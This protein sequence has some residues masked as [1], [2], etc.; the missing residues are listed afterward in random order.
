MAKRVVGDHPGANMGKMLKDL[1]ADAVVSVR[2]GVLPHE[3]AEKWK[4]NTAFFE[5]AEREWAPLFQQVFADFLADDSLPDSLRAMLEEGADPGH[6][7]GFFV[8]VLAFIGMA[9]A[10][11]PQFGAVYVRGAVYEL[12][13]KTQN[14]PMSPADAADAVMRGLLDEGEGAEYAAMAGITGGIF[15]TM[16]ALIGEPPGVMDMVALW[17]RGAINSGQLEQGIKYS[18]IHDTYIPMVEQMAYSTMSPADAIEL[19]IKGVV[20]PSEAATWFQ[21]GGGLIEQ[22]N[23]LY[24]AAGDAIGNEQVLGLLNQG[25]ASES[26]VEATFG[27]SRMNPIFYPLA[28]QLR[29]K[30]LEPFQIAELLKANP[31]LGPQAAEWMTGLGYNAEQITAFIATN[32]KGAVATTHT[33]TQAMI[34][35]LFTDQVI[36]EDVAM[37]QLANL[38]YDPGSATMIL[39]LAIAKQALSQR[40]TAV[41]AVRSALLARKIDGPTASTDLDLLG[42]PPAARD[43]WLAAWAV[44]ATTKVAELTAAQLGSMAKKGIITADVLIARY[45]AMGYSTDD[46]NLLAANYGVGPDVPAS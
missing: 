21:Q 23:M 13:Q 16:T 19:A 8:Q 33:E 30:F 43:Q 5:G 25:L 15:D 31:S 22:F 9:L 11:I 27:R 35:Q 37:A 6:Q 36:T 4:H 29:H 12:N 46:A 41:S 17:R 39:E 1:I 45:V 26:D 10:M 32:A 3:M 20:S 7:T 40:D 34:V 28:M 14:V 42:I 24:E 2:A 18:R 38:G 44:E